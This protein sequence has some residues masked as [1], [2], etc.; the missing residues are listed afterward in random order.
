MEFK[1]SP[2]LQYSMQTWKQQFGSESKLFLILSAQ[3]VPLFCILDIFI[4]LFLLF[5]LLSSISFIFYNCLSRYFYLILSVTNFLSLFFFSHYLL[6]FSRCC[7]ANLIEI[8]VEIETPDH[9]YY[10]VR[11]I[12]KMYL[13]S[14]LVF[15]SSS[16]LAQVNT[17]IQRAV[18]KLQVAFF[19]TRKVEP[20]E[21]LCWVST[22]FITSSHFCKYFNYRT[23]IQPFFYYYFVHLF[24]ICVFF[25][26]QES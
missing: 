2:I 21:E 11:Y 9:H 19:T 18:L 25:V 15:C 10:H 26:L 1:V 23:L 20:Y 8:P 12:T 6:F 3:K 16:N 4:L 24:F 14:R 22:S 5:I 13:V 7:D 17:F